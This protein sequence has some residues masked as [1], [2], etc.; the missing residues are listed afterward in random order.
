MPTRYSAEML[1]R[2][3]AFLFRS[4]PTQNS[5]FPS[6]PGA[7]ATS[8]NSPQDLGAPIAR[9]QLSRDRHERLDLRNR[10]FNFLNANHATFVDCDFSYSVF[11]RAYCHAAKFEGCRFVGCRFYDSNLREASF[12]VC[13][14]KYATF[15]R[16]LLD[17]A[18]MVASL[19]IEPNLRRD[20]L[21]NLRAN[22]VEI[23]DYVS[24]RLFVLAEVEATIDHL[25]R[26]MRGTGDYYRRKYPGPIA[27]LRA[28]IALARLKVMGWIWGH[29]ERPARIIGSAV[30]LLGVL[31]IVNLWAVV[32]NIGWDA[33]DAGLQVF[34][35]NL[36]LL[37]DASPE[38]KFRGFAVVDY[39][40]IAMRYV[41]IGLFISVL[42]KSISH[43]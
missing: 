15:H 3:H 21:Q 40:L 28:A 33:S 9:V 8:L 7:V 42:F 5:A 16:T 24:Q 37:L 18:E 25:S 1:N 10:Q 27:R 26:A 41:Y 19:P 13:D 35:Y 6:A 39:A 43:R 36:D 12:Q 38:S 4:G 20:S 34:R 30:V 22:A 14:F 17:P 29:G 32:P 11:E 2:L 31:T 23:G